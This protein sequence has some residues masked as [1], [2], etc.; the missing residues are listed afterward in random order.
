MELKPYHLRIT[1][2]VQ[3]AP[4]RIDDPKELQNANWSLWVLDMSKKEWVPQ[5]E[6]TRPGEFCKISKIEVLGE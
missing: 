1:F 5:S 6:W 4:W 3:V 2:D